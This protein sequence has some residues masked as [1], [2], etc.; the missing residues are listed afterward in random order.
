MML[1]EM[2]ANIEQAGRLIAEKRHRIDSLLY[3]FSDRLRAVFPGESARA[4]K[5][6]EA[7]SVTSSR[8]RKLSRQLTSTHET[9]RS[10]S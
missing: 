1:N 7:T 10:P 3:G 8:V 5:R 2:A 9:G 4:N 6:S